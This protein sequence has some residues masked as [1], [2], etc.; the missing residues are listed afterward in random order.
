MFI[1]V[2]DSKKSFFIH[3]VEWQCRMI[4]KGYQNLIIGLG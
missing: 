3:E 2:K 1:A 4:S